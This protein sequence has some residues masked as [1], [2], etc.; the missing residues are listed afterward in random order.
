MHKFVKFLGVILVAALTFSGQS[1]ALSAT[2]Q[3]DKVKVELLPAFAD[4]QKNETLDIL[5]KITPQ[6]GWHIYW[7]NP[8]DAGLPTQVIWNLS[9]N[10]KIVEMGHSAPQKYNVDGLVLFGFGKSAYWKY[11]VTHSENE[12]I[13]LQ[14]KVSWLACKEECVPETVRISLDIPVLKHKSERHPLSRWQDEALIAGNSFPIKWKGSA[15][16]D[17]QDDKLMLLLKSKHKGLFAN[18]QNVWFIP[19]QKNMIDNFS[20]PILGQDGIGN[21][22]LSIPVIDVAQGDFS[23]V[24]LI[25]NSHHRKAYEINPTKTSGLHLLPSLNNVEN[26]IL[27]ILIMAFI[28]G[29]ILNFMPCIFPILSI[30]AIALVQGAYNKRR[31]RIEAIFYVLGVIVCFVV[32]ASILVLLRKQGEHIGWGFQLQSPTFVA[33]MIV[34]FFL[35]FLMLLDLINVKNPF[36]NKVGRISFAKQKLNAFFTGLFAVLIA[37]PCTAPFMGIAIGYTLS[38]PIY[39]YYPVFLA[40]SVGYALPFVLIAFFPRILLRIL[41]KPGKW[42]SVLKKIFAIPVLFT[43]FWLMWVLW[44]LTSDKTSFMDHLNWLPY[45][46]KMVNVSLQK[47]QPIFIDFTAKWCITC[48]ANEKLALDSKDFAN[49]V[50]KYNI[51]LFKADWTNKSQT[52]TDALAKYGRNSIPLYV[53]YSSS[54]DYVLLPQLLTP[55]IIKEYIN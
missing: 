43:C 54:G 50:K 44:H 38:K 29:I 2:A 3:T 37:S 11:R 39:V 14:A 25:E 45:D 53:Y 28:G 47:G 36:A 35:V 51:K 13:N 6:N 21:Y 26:G 23:G 15:S 41:P 46:E 12:K 55:S 4:V 32:M 48:L 27:G 40:L 30:K 49:L 24:L 19:Y 18:A 52:I 20:N 9:P 10:M 8:G 33:C 5:V 31:A 22:S 1:F 34:I 17:I 42:M 16:Y 7:D